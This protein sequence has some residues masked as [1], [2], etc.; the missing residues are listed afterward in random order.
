MLRFVHSLARGLATQTIAILA[1]TIAMSGAAYTVAAQ[2][3][4]EKNSVVSKSIKNRQVKT[5]DLA[6]EAVNGSRLAPDSVDGGKIVDGAIT[7]AEVD[8]KTLGRVPS[9]RT[10]EIGGLAWQ[11]TTGSCTPPSTTAYVECRSTVVEMPA[12]GQ[13]VL[14]GHLAISH[15]TNNIYEA[16]A[17]CEF[18]VNGTPVP[19]SVTLITKSAGNTLG[20][21]RSSMFDVAIVPAGTAT[22]GIWCADEYYS[23]FH[24]VELLALASTAPPAP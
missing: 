16:A 20:Q 18:R 15:R 3:V 13:L 24:D 19:G 6:Q 9:A 8:E 11:S 4:A 12:A 14:I 17:W 22:V 10:A 2:N 7:G 21:I 23:R 5:K 1:L